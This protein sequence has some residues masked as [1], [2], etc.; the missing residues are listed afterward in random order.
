M[1]PNDR[2]QIRFLTL[3]GV[4]ILVLLAVTWGAY[5]LFSSAPV[6]SA[7]P[8]FEP[9]EAQPREANAPRIVLPAPKSRPTPDPP[10]PMNPEWPPGTQPPDELP[11]KL[12]NGTP[13]T[14]GP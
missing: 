6:P 2:S 9:P 12:P 3:G 5:E 4:V 11:H 8:P 7:S 14:I 1:E 10:E 13:G